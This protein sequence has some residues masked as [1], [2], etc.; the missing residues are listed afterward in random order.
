MSVACDSW[1]IRGHY[2]PYISHT[3]TSQ[4]LIG[5]GKTNGRDVCTCYVRPLFK[6]D[7]LS[8]F[9]DIDPEISMTLWLGPWSNCGFLFVQCLLLNAALNPRL[10]TAAVQLYSNGFLCEQSLTTCLIFINVTEPR[11]PFHQRWCCHLL[12]TDQFCGYFCFRK[13]HYLM[14]LA[15]WDLCGS[16]SLKP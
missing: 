14:P 4:S 8:C 13:T 7:M 15:C 5:P 3:R 1:F 16:V 6:Q 10:W 9:L 2:I 11:N 12:F